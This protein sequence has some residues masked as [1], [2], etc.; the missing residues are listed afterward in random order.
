LTD[1]KSEGLKRVMGTRTLIASAINLT[2]G[3]GIFALPADVAG[4]LGTASW[5]AYVVCIS[6][7]M[8]MLLCF[9]SLG[10]K[11][12]E[13]GGAYVYVELMQVF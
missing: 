4:Y 3:A 10:T 7:L 8:L 1:L 5:M 11:F 6:L 12:T 2:I 9:V 13:T